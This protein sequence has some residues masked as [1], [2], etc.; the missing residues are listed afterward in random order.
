[1]TCAFSVA[2]LF[3]PDISLFA[4]GVLIFNTEFLPFCLLDFFRT[5]PLLPHDRRTLHALKVANFNAVTYFT[6]EEVVSSLFNLYAFHI[7]S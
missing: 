2:H 4:L 3:S 5:K 1:M 7:C 6:M